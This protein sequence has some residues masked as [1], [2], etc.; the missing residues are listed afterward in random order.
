MGSP[1][2]TPQEIAREAVKLLTARRLPPT[3]DNFQAAYHEVAGTRPLQPFSQS[4]WAIRLRSFAVG[5]LTLVSSSICRSSAPVV[6]F[7]R[8]SVPSCSR[9]KKTPDDG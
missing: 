3:P 5:C 9:R 2:S 4:C 1:A 6:S 8:E 7:F